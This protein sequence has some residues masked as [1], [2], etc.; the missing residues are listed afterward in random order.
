[1]GGTPSHR[2]LTQAVGDPQVSRSALLRSDAPRTCDSTGKA[3]RGRAH[4]QGPCGGWSDH[5][6]SARP[7]DRYDGC[8]GLGPRHG[9]RVRCCDR[10]REDGRG[11]P[12]RN[13]HTRPPPRALTTRQPHPP[14]G[15]RTA[16]SLC[17]TLC[18]NRE[19]KQQRMS[20]F[21][22]STTARARQE[23]ADRLRSS[24][25]RSVGRSGA[26]RGGQAEGYAQAE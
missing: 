12:R 17:L 6:R 20:S 21:G 1:M 5:R 11:D 13:A 22:S 15:D 18:P 7:V 25:V 26:D 2:P 3:H 23:L 24:L 8:L 4:F 14:G 10:A 9:L 19:P 16:S